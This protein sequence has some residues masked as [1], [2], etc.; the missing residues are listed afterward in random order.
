MVGTKML[1]S[2]GVKSSPNTLLLNSNKKRSRILENSDC[3]ERVYQEDMQVD[4]P[5]RD[6]DELGMDE[7]QVA[8]KIA[9][10][11]IKSSLFIAVD[12]PASSSRIDEVFDMRPVDPEVCC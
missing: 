10:E 2:P 11:G 1:K 4:I 3:E 6:I 5:R 9:Q 8:K 7:L 12:I